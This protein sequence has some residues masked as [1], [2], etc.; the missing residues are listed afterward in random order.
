MRLLHHDQTG[1][2]MLTRFDDHER[3]AYTILSHTWGK[4]EEEVSLADTMN[5][6]GKEKAGYK[7]IR[8]CGEQ[9]QRD[10]IRYFWVDTCCIDKSNMAE[11]SLAIRSMFRWYQDAT[12][13]YVYLS[14]VSTKKRKLDGMLAET[15]S[16]H[17]MTSSRWFKRGWTLQELLAPSSVELFSQE[18]ERLGDKISL[19]P[20]ISR[21]TGI[22]QE[23]LQGDTLAQFDI[24]DR[25]R[26]R[27]DRKT[28]LKEDMAYSLSG[29]CDVDIAPLYGEGEEEAF[30]RLH[31]EIQKLKDCLRD[32]RQ[33]DPKDDKKRIE[34]TKGGLLVDSYRWVLSN[35]AFQQWQRDPQTQLLWV[36]GDPGKGKTM[37][38][39]GIIDEL[40]SSMPKTALLSYF[41]CQATFSH[42][43]SA[44]AV[45]RGL[46]YMLITQ[47]P[48]LA[49][50]IYKRYDLAGKRL[51][52][53]AN[54]WVALTEI[55][56]DVLRDPGLRTG[57]LLID[58]L[59]EC[60]IDR[61]R[62][63]RFIAIH[64]SSSSRLKWI[65]S[66]RN[67]PEIE[68][69]LESAAG[70]LLLS[71]EL[72]A[73]SI[74]A[75]VKTFIDT[76]VSRLAEEERYDEQIW[77]VMSEYL[78]ANA[79][80]TFL[81]VA[82]VCQ[83]LKGIAKRHVMKKLKSIPPGLE[84]FY[85]RMMNGISESEDAETCGC[86]L[87]TTA[88]LFRPVVIEELVAIVEPLKEFVDDPETVLE[89]IELY[90]CFLTVRENTVYYVHQ[91]AQDFL[92]ADAKN[93]I[94]PNGID[95]VHQGIFRNS[96]EVL[97]SQLHRDMYKLK[98]PGAAIDFAQSPSPDPLAA[99]RYSCV[100][101]IDHVCNSKAIFQDSHAG[102]N[103]VGEEITIFIKEKYLYWLEALSLCKSTTKCV[104]AMKALLS[105]AEVWHHQNA[106]LSF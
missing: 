37:L 59:D 88:I 5:G 45:L 36:K 61:S 58:A 63:L 25:L 40:R 20:L 62:L 52:E 7:K 92:L 85:K 105:L 3:P 84:P 55:W 32:L 46:L 14:D 9:T 75:A 16:E 26:W 41:L 22:P 81:W 103:V 104:T 42:L 1:E 12:K 74:S 54:A 4:D 44:T 94:F 95:V 10:G 6:G 57:Y 68:R 91:S 97:S 29:I 86:V 90:G 15:T 77:N 71:L 30:K 47:Q 35:D 72:N 98:A 49:S 13:C 96:L 93:E 19:G 89:I 78:S 106:K 17:P 67:W 83:H 8:F 53:D 60:T 100:Y 34:E 76:K 23:V 33:G 66:S 50:H 31:K 27:G 38:L 73:Q 11:L 102:S 80:D 64:S 65:V 51:F 2:L 79:N 24:S 99:L 21:I 56:V 18:W 70:K 87:A 48:S 101:W 28:K 82:L 39:C 69:C 43:N